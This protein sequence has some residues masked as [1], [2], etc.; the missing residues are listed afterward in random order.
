MTD[1]TSGRREPFISCGHLTAWKQ[2]MLVQ[3]DC[4]L[5]SV[6]FTAALVMT[7]YGK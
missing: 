3:C 4:P 5:D 7:S 2:P 6:L 1:I